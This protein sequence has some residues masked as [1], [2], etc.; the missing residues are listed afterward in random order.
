MIQFGRL[1]I[2]AVAEE[3]GVAVSGDRI[4]DAIRSDFADAVIDR[5]GDI[6]VPRFVDRHAARPVQQCIR[7]R[8]AV[9]VLA[10]ATAGQTIRF[11]YQCGSIGLGLAIIEILIVG[12]SL[13]R[14]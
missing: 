4:D 11:R 7:G 2:A 10:K 6:N 12:K 1:C 13:Q 8:A 9:V 5:V 14:V 3:S